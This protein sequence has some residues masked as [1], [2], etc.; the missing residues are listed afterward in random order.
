[1]TNSAAKPV[2]GA[3][4][5]QKV[6]ER[7]RGTALFEER[8]LA[9]HKRVDRLFAYLMML[10]WVAGI[11]LAV[12]VSPYAWAGK[13]HTVH[14]HVF[15]A[16]FLGGLI[17]AMPVLLALKRP[18]WETTRMVI[19]VAQM[20]WSALLIHLSGGRIETHFH[21]FGS[22]AFLSFYRD[23]RV[24]VPATVVVAADHFL[25]QMYWPESVF[26]VLVPESWRFLEHAGWVVFEDI[27]LLIS[28]ITSVT[29]LK[30][31]AAQQ[32]H[33]EFVDRLERE[34][35]I[36]STIQTSI[37]PRRLK[38]SGLD[39]A[40]K[41]VPATEVGGDYYEILPT[42]D[43]CWIGIG[44]VAGHGLRAG[45]VMLQAQSAAEALIRSV[46]EDSPSSVLCGVNRVLFENVRNR[47]GSEEHMTMS[48]LHYRE[49]GHIVCA[50]AHEEAIVWRA[51][52]RKCELIPVKGTWLGAIEDIAAATVETT[53]ALG[54]GDLLVL[55]TDGLTESRN[56]KR[57]QFGLPRLC[58]LVEKASGESVEIICETIV[59]AALAWS[60]DRPDDDVTLMVCRQVGIAARAAA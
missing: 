4:S 47:L 38:V 29:E 12:T 51:K 56:D 6:T 34:M 57:E 22:L 35:E 31:S 3:V 21:V 9:S 14:S 55:Y 44:D 13:T 10:Q 58:D 28:C 1:M 42:K 2:L 7:A 24:L 48:L 32:A 8:F 30:T 23:W 19:A 33:I 41:M 45:L 26:G 60:M 15:I 40:A 11:I 36:A 5:D 17:T 37:L 59:T 16:V 50:G 54:E 27:F 39:V 20:L 52:T 49:Y 53:I 46:P 43:G 25:R 18:G